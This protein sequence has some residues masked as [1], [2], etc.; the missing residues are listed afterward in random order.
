MKKLIIVLLLLAATLISTSAQKVNTFP[1]TNDMF[2]VITYRYITLKNETK[3]AKAAQNFYTPIFKKYGY[4]HELPGD[5]YGGPCSII[6]GFYKGGYI[7]K[8]KANMFV[9]TK[10]KS[11]SVIFMSA[12]NDGGEGDYGYLNITLTVY[13]KALANKILANVKASGFKQSR[14][15]KDLYC[16]GNKEVRYDYNPEEKAYNFYYSIA[17]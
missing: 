1:S 4:T 3:D 16:N 10:K 6:D 15:D 17:E 7:N 2:K 11:A 8:K 12:C 13:D 9:P 14:D 5:G